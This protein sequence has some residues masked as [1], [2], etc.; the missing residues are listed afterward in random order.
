[1]KLFREIEVASAELVGNHSVLVPP[2]PGRRSPATLRAIAERDRLLREAAS[3]FCAGMSELA[4]AVKLSAALKQ[5]STSGWR[6][7]AAEQTCPPRHAGS[8][9][10]MCWRILKV[11]DA[12]VSSETVRRA[13]RKVPVKS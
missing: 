4:A 11:R 12:S 3:G 2:G 5:Y 10:E 6:R 9:R 7:D 13:L 1:M 8:L